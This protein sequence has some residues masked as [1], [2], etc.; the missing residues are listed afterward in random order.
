[1][2][3]SRGSAPAQLTEVHPRTGASHDVATE[4]G[5]AWLTELYS[6]DPDVRVRLNMITAVTGAAVGTDGTSE[7]LSSRTDR[8]ILGIIRASAD[9]VV[10]GA[11]TVRAE[12]YVIPRAARLA[13]L[14]TTGDLRGHRL[15]DDLSGVVLVCPS[16]VVDAVRERAGVDGVD[17]LGVGEGDRL[18]PR[19]VV[20]ALATIGIERMVCEGGPAVASMFARADLIDEY[21]VTVAPALV[22]AERPFLPLDVEVDTEVAGMLVDDAAFSYLRL[23][24]RRRDRALAAMR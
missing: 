3:A 11:A 14:T 22:P 16:S 1:M 9:A 17:I 19:E 12:G 10:V 7:T 24:P 4:S 8:A 15:D 2:T 5:R 23:R 21:C 18:D 13:I 20:A 6:P